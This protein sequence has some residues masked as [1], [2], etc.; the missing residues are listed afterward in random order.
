MKKASWLIVT[1]V[2][3]A[4]AIAAPPVD[5][6]PPGGTP[7]SKDRTE[8][9][10][11]GLEGVE[12][13]E[14]LN[15]PLPLEL[16]FKDDEGHTVRLGDYFNQGK[17]VILT[18]NYFRCP[19]LCTL[20]LN[21]MVDALK[22]LKWLPGE[23]FELVTV[24][25]DP[26]ETPRLARA[27]KE[28]YIGMYGDIRAAKGWHF[29]TGQQDAIKAL[30]SATG[31]GYR[32]NAERQEYAHKAVLMICTPDGLLS[33]YIGNVQFDPSTLRL[34]LVE[35]G[36]GKIGSPFDQFLLYCFHY[37]AAS[38]RYAPAAMNIMQVG[39][40]LAVVGVGA[41]VIGLRFRSGRGRTGSVGSSAAD[42]DVG[43]S[44]SQ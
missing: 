2:A 1:A 40:V 21:G 43:P 11:G 4:G 30:T 15:E 29:L 17:P 13:V 22:E 16:F 33:R 31:F 32:W 27:K 14:H 35:A 44:E 42:S 9:L 20:Q 38:G 39:A 26:T 6:P 10:P 25:F 3:A 5:V 34:S 12:V 41:L 19:M 8:R 7:G 37:D 18:L 23:E 28:S 36:A 24:S